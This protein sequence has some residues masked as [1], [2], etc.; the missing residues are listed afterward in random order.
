MAKMVGLLAN[1]PPSLTVLF[2]WAGVG[3]ASGGAWIG[4]GLGFEPCKTVIVTFEVVA[5]ELIVQVDDSGVTPIN[6]NCSMS[7]PEPELGLGSPEGGMARVTVNGVSCPPPDS[8]T[9]ALLG[10][11]VKF[12]TPLGIELS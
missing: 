8:G 9:I 5:L 4:G 6:V 10:D 12:W 7:V 3:V 11:V 2:N 1:V